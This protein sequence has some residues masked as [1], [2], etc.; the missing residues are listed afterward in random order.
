MFELD[1][2]CRSKRKVYHCLA[3]KTQSQA[4]ILHVCAH[5]VAVVPVG[6]TVRPRSKTWLRRA[7]WRGA[8]AVVVLAEVE[9]KA[10]PPGTLLV[11]GTGAMPLSSPYACG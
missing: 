10:L 4:V 11:P 1:E 3:C 9:G 8:V 6:W 5:C 7:P 2:A